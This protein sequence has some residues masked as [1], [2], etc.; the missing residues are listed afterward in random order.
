MSKNR[1]TIIPGLLL[2]TKGDHHAHF[3]RIRVQRKPSASAERFTTPRSQMM[4][5]TP[6]TTTT[7]TATLTEVSIPRA[8]NIVTSSNATTDSPA[9]RRNVRRRQLR[10]RRCKRR[11]RDRLQRR[12]GGR[13]STCDD[14][15]QHG[16]G[17]LRLVCLEPAVWRL[18]FLRRIR[19]GPA[20][21]HIPGEWRLHARSRHFH[22]SGW[23]F[24]WDVIYSWQWQLR[25]FSVKGLVG[26]GCM[27]RNN[28][29]ASNG[30]GSIGL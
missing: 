5:Q 19:R 26:G 7:T 1:S 29:F 11:V 15:R 13:H 23:R 28:L 17:L 18:R 30:R 21:L 12:R 9:A 4:L 2:T 22:C 20:L 25:G 8:L 16:D 10:Q 14:E 6:V 24:A 3:D 27:S